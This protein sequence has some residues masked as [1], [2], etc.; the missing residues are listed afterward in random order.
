MNILNVEA[1]TNIVQSQLCL[2]GNKELYVKNSDHVAP[3]SLHADKNKIFCFLGSDDSAKGVDLSTLAEELEGIDDCTVISCSSDIEDNFFQIGIKSSDD[4]F[5]ATIN[6]SE[7]RKI[8]GVCDLDVHPQYEAM[9]CMLG[10][11]IF[12]KSIN[13]LGSFRANVDKNTV[14]VR[15][16]HGI[17]K[18]NISDCEKVNSPEN[19]GQ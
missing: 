16:V 7:I 8:G 1:L 17:E 6:S 3:F 11:D 19:D 14:S 5:V 2:Y 13:R 9:N 12:N 10:D 15:T 4:N 18:W